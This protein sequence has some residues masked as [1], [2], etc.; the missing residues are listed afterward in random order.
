MHTH[1]ADTAEIY[2]PPAIEAREP[3][4]ASLKT[5]SNSPS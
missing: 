4:N 3:I 1:S 2:E 5:P